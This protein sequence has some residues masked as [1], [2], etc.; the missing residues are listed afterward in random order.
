MTFA[1]TAGHLTADT[2][3]IAAY[4]SIAQRAER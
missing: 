3:P 1:P 4:M 2:L